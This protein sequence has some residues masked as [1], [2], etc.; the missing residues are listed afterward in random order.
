MPKILSKEEV[1]KRCAE[2][3][4]ELVSEYINIRTKEEHKYFI[5]MNIILD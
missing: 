4:C 1:N 5:C 3:E 2:L